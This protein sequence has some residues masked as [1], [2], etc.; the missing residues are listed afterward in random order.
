MTIW[1]GGL[2]LMTLGVLYAALSGEDFD[3]HPFLV[4]AVPLMMLCFG[5]GLVRF[6]Q[7]IARGQRQS[8]Q[9]FISNDLKA[10]THI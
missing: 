8:I 3:G 6:G 4:L 1:F 2:G 9:N 7:W 5:V 10:Y